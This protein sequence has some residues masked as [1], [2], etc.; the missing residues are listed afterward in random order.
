MLLCHEGDRLMTHLQ[1]A[2]QGLITPEMIRAENA[3][4]DR[5]PPFSRNADGLLIA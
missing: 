3:T 4:S 2:R 1:S 5:S